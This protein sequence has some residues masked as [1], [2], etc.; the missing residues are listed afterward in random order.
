MKLLISTYAC[1]PARGSEHAVGWNWVTEA[2]RLGHQVWAFASP[3]HRAAIEA[4]CRNDP[5]LGGIHWTFPE[6]KGWPLT[7]GT[8]P[9]WERTYNLLWQMAAL[10]HARA[11]RST[12]RFDAIHHL[13]WAGIRAPTFLGSLGAPLII[14]PVGGGETTPQSLRDQLG[15]RGRLLER[16]RDISNATI[17]LNP[18]VRAGLQHAAVIFTSTADTQ[19]IFKGTMGEK[20]VV[21][22]Q[23]ESAWRPRDGGGA[24]GP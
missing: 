17:T 10:R 11:L 8:E 15:P 21:F 22:S 14:G 16:L 12:I 6:V 1:A 4:A 20:T 2:H 23:L 7:P 18:L 9:R 13:T 24:P 5:T 3:V 19:R